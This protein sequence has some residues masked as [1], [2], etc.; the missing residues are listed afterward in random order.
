MAFCPNSPGGPTPAEIVRQVLRDN[1]IEAA[2]RFLQA[3]MACIDVAEVECC[4]VHCGRLVG[5]P[6]IRDVNNYGPKA[7]ANVNATVVRGVPLGHRPAP[8]CHA[9]VTPS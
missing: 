2:Q 5:G 6:F 1:V 9:I 7:F 3:G 4:Q 8:A